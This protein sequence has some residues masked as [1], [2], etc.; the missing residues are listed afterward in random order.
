MVRHSARGGHSSSFRVERG[1]TLHRRAE[2]RRAIWEDL[3]GT[4][5]CRGCNMSLEGRI[6]G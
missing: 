5:V 6:Y 1:K 3:D 2:E 4:D